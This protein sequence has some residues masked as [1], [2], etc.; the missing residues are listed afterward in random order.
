MQMFAIKKTIHCYQALLENHQQPERPFHFVGHQANLRMLER[1]CERCDIPPD[2]HHS[3]VE[4]FGNTAGA[5]SA[6]VISQNWDRWSA[7][8]DLAVAGVGAGLTW[9]SY[10][11]RFGAK[12]Q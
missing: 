8:D 12:K 4:L 7:E 10:V 11:M 9:S 6:S 2:R 5:G 1:V 3:N